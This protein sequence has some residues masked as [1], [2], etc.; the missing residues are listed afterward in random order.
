[1]LALI[2][3]CGPVD[4]DERSD[5]ADAALA[6]FQCAEI[7]RYVDAPDAASETDRLSKY[8]FGQA[9]LAGGDAI[10]PGASLEDGMYPGASDDFWIG[11]AL[12]QT[13]IDTNELLEQ[14]VPGDDRSNGKRFA[15]K[16][17]IAAQEF[18]IRNCRLIGR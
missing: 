14:Q 12:A 16:Q 10:Y 7:A 11:Y 1:M 6:A 5:A 17:R 4:A 3:A 15:E 8:G 9:R 18:G 13:V 2:A